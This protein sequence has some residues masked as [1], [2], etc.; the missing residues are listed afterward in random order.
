MLDKFFR[1]LK[2]YKNVLLVSHKGRVFDFRVLCTAISRCGL[3]QSFKETVTGFVDSLQAVKRKYPKLPSYTLESLSCSFCRSS[4]NPSNAED[5]VRVLNN[6]IKAANLS[7]NEM[8]KSS[9]TSDYHFQFELLLE[10]NSQNIK[11]LQCLVDKD[12]LTM[13][14]A[15]NIAGSGLALSH[16]KLV[17]DRD[18][19]DG[20][21]RVLSARNRNRNH[22]IFSTSYQLYTIVPKICKFL[23]SA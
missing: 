9:Y 13:S 20:L 10:T 14:M 8:M 2:Q 18:G 21:T 23:A 15:E 22:R 3:E 6:I 11:S 1:W 7:H 17:V 16:L 19:E 5:N 12:I 4:Y